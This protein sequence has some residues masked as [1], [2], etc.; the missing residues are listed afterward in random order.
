MIFLIFSGLLNAKTSQKSL[1]LELIR[2][3]QS[4]ILDSTGIP[5]EKQVLLFEGDSE[6]IDYLNKISSQKK[7]SNNESSG[8]TIL[9]QL[10]RLE[11]ALNPAKEK[12]FRNSQYIRKLKLGVDFRHGA[13]LYE[14]QGSI[15]DKISKVEIQDLLDE[16]FPEIIRGDYRMGQPAP[17]AIIISS[18]AVLALGAALFFIRS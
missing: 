12:S 3:L 9:V 5:P 17:N 14:W 1:C 15:S 8:D 13:K 18:L 2:D 6:T 10:Q 16:W 4:S 7:I 11:L